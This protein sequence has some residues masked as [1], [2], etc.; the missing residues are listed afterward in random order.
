MAALLIWHYCSIMLGYST[1]VFKYK[2]TETQLDI[3]TNQRR[4]ND[5]GT[6]QKHKPL[7]WAGY[8]V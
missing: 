2:F 3:D 4:M 5:Q 6:R 7:L 1:I 8:T